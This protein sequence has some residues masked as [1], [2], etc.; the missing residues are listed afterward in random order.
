MKTKKRTTE[1]LLRDLFIVDNTNFTE[2]IINS[3]EWEEE[4]CI[5][6]TKYTYRNYT[7]LI[8]NANNLIKFQR[9]GIYNLIMKARLTDVIKCY[10]QVLLIN[11][12]NNMNAEN[13]IW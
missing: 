2:E 4:S 8:Q 7:F 3:W 12:V 6:Y 1:E 10:H 13:S 5:A 11:L 9:K